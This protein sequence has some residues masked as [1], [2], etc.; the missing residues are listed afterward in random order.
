[1][2]RVE[3]A[4]LE[5]YHAADASALALA[6]LAGLD[7]AELLGLAIRRHPATHVVVL[8]SD[9]APLVDPKFAADTRG[10][11]VPR[12]ASVFR[13]F[14]IAP[15]PKQKSVARGTRAAVRV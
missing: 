6:D 8:A 13:L 3:W 11:L 9:A 15:A 7:E 10:R 5:S 1:M 14:G 4:W 12:P 2:A